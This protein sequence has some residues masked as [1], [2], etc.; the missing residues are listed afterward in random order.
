MQ[1]SNVRRV[2]SISIAVLA[3]LAGTAG[4]ADA[5]AWLPPQGDGTVSVVFQDVLMNYHFLPT[6]P[7]DRGQIRSDSLIVDMTYGL[8]DNVAITVGIPW[9]AARYRGA[10]PHPLVDSSGPVPVLYGANPADDGSYH[11]AFQDFRFDIRYNIMKRGVVLTPFVGTIVPSHN[12]TYFAHAATGRDLKELQLGVA[13]ARLLDSLVSGLFVQGRYSYGFTEQVLDVSH[14]RS[15]MDLEVG[16]FLTPKMRLLA[17]GTGQLTHGGIDLTLNS[18]VDLG[19]L[20]FSHHDQIDRVNYVNL[21]GGAAYSLTEAV[22]VF[23][24]VLHTV[25]QRNG[26]AID[27]GLTVGLSWSFS[28]TRGGDHAIAAGERTLGRCACQKGMK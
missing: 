28:T 7:V 15:N 23:G 5:Q 21:G 18:R 27:H 4:S 13:A 25:A 9:V 26:H 16:Y 1:R 6:T 19:P 20:L 10:T 17:L 8:T 12:Y 2:T 24:S 3:M 11:A 22:D 14:N